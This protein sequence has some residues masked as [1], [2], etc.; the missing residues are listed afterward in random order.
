MNNYVAFVINAYSSR[1]SEGLFKGILKGTLR[2]ALEPTVSAQL[3]M[4]MGYILAVDFLFLKS[5]SQI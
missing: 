4:P 1:L 2:T 3:L 5:P